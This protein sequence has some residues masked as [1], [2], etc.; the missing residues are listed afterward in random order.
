MKIDRHKKSLAGSSQLT[1]MIGSSDE[2]SIW[3]TAPYLGFWARKLWMLMKPYYCILCA[4][5]QK[6]RKIRKT[7][8]S[9]TRL[10]TGY[11]C[12]KY[13][14]FIA[15]PEK[16]FKYYRMSEYSFEDLLNNDLKQHTKGYSYECGD[17]TCWLV[18]SN[19]KVNL[20]LYDKKSLNSRQ[21]F[22]FE[23]IK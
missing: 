8:L 20:D 16:I 4:R 14:L 1:N 7:P 9:S 13:R 5:L 17:R 15:Y 3:Q 10:I 19:I 12:Q 6:R 21:L 2:R 18:G 11:F 22:R 23:R